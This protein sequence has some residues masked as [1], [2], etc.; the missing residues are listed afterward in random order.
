[1]K[2]NFL[3]TDLSVAS[4]GAIYDKNLFEILKGI[5]ANV[6]L[7][8]DQYFINK[9]NRGSGLLTFNRYYNKSI[10]DLFNCDYLIMNSRLYTRMM[11]FNIK[12]IAKRYPNTK[13][14]IIHHHS[15]FMN[16][17]GCLK[18]IHKYFESRVLKTGDELVIP[19]E[20]V[21]KQI[22]KDFNLNNIK[23]LP[24][25]FEK[26]EYPI[27][28]LDS[29]IILFVGNIE[30]RKGLIYGLKAFKRISIKLPYYKYYIVGK[31]KKSDKYFQKLKRY[32]YKNHLENKVIFEGR[33]SNERLEW[34]YANVELFLFPSL[35]EGYGWV[36]VEAMGRGIPVV[37][38]DNSAMPYTIKEGINGL[39][40]KNKDWK[41]MG[42][43]TYEL[44]INR[45]KMKVLQKGALNTYSNVSDQEK[46]NKMIEEYVRSWR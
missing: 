3:A 8:N 7:Y 31:Y 20:Y 23:Y 39:L 17:G 44:L 16:H 26:K 19:N 38:F 4:G 41:Q 18:K 29:K 14:I 6:F 24:S 12:K 33:I 37:A 5:Y 28:K 21:I 34:L 15:N 25:S 45:K 30:S 9:Y 13:L 32:V 10:Q 2:I 27:S 40:I 46:L 1:M 35:L 11:I 22:K 43:R 42:E 36:M